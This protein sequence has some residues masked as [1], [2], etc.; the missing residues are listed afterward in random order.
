MEIKNRIRL[1]LLV[2]IGVISTNSLAVNTYS[3][4]YHEIRD[5]VIYSKS[6]TT[7]P[8]Y[9]GMVILRLTSNRRPHLL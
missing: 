9:A 2:V 8:A 4:S 1:A 6:D 7:T 5:V 3:N